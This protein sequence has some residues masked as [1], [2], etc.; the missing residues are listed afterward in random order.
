VRTQSRPSPLAVVMLL[1]LGAFPVHAAK[2][3]EARPWAVGVSQERQTKALQLFKD[4]NDALRLGIFKDARAAYEE[5]LKHWDHPAIHYN[6]G[7]TLVNLEKPLEAYPHFEEALKYGEA[8][9]DAERFAQANRFKNLLTSQLARL[10]VRCD[11]PGA[12]VILDGDELFVGPGIISRLIKAG[13]HTVAASKD[14]YIPNEV[15]QPMLPGETTSFD[16][17]LYTEAE[18]TEYRRKFDAWIPFAVMGAGMGIAGGGGALLYAANGL[19]FQ[20]DEDMQAC[21]LDSPINGCSNSDTLLKLANDRS[22]ALGQQQLAVAAF[23]LGGAVAATGVILA[24]INQPQPYRI[25]PS[26]KKV[27][28]AVMP[29]VSPTGGGVSAMLRF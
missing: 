23:G 15:R 28:V 26:Q 22:A 10:E 25:D 29:L 16:M 2:R 1:L 3:S 5:A 19:V 8:P 11:T 7:L 9:L 18:L 24:I 12:R 13:T 21:A 27:N 17:R 4:G 20:Y 14:G 6:L